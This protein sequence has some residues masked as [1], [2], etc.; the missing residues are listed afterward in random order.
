MRYQSVAIEALCH[1]V[2]DVVIQTSAIEGMLAYPDKT[3][4]KLLLDNLRKLEK[5]KAK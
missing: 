1:H 4:I 3:S 2:P 5:K